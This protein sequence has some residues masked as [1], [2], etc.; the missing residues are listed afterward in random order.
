MT[1]QGPDPGS[2]P[3]T[4]QAKISEATLVVIHRR[5]RSFP[6]P[7][8]PARDA[9]G[10]LVDNGTNRYN[11]CGMDILDACAHEDAVETHELADEPPDGVGANSASI[12]LSSGSPESIVGCQCIRS[13]AWGRD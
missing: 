2:W 12:T 5:P 4:S 7:G 8:E 9:A 10:D 11:I 13:A 6:R 3:D 1:P